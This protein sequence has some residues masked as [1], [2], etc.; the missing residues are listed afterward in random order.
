M[1]EAFAWLGTAVAVGDAIGA[2]MAGALAQTAGAP[3]IFAP[4]G[5]TG[6]A[7]LAAATR[8]PGT[9]SRRIGRFGAGLNAPGDSAPQ[10]A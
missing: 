5:A 2:A 6:P 9:R 10:P 1:T 8:L 7:A 4:A 3:L